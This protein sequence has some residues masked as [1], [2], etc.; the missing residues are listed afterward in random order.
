MF[1]GHIPNNITSLKNLYHLNLAANA[2]SGSIPHHLS[3]LTAMTTPNVVNYTTMIEI[4]PILSIDMPVVIKRQ[5][6]K[7]KGSSVLE[8]SSIDFSCNYL[9]GQKFQRK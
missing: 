4:F 7:Y 3:N 2:I 8:I 5:E 9:N 1:Y 6:L